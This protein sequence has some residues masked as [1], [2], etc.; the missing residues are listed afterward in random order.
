MGSI[1][2]CPINVL[3]GCFHNSNDAASL[4][5]ACKASQRP[6]R[7]ERRQPGPAAKDVLRASQPEA[8]TSDHDGFA[9]AESFGYERVGV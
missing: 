5:G 9:Q 4:C 2:I 6:R 7:A 1:S 3:S 8:Q